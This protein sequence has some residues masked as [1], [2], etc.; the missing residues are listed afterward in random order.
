MN[1]IA[2]GLFKRQRDVLNE[3]ITEFEARGE[4]R[5]A[6]GLAGIQNLC[7]AIYDAL[8]DDGHVM[9]EPMTM[10]DI[11]DTMLPMLDEDVLHDCDAAEEED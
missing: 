5:W 6:E 7:D 1:R 9:L 11:D 8:C 2:M 4:D 3:V 10:D